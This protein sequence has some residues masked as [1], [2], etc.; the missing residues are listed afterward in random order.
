MDDR[1]SRGRLK[2]A[3]S[4]LS[5]WDNLVGP[6]YSASQ[7]TKVCGEISQEALEDR[8]EHREILGLQTADGVLVYPAFQFDEQNRIVQGLPEVFQCFPADCVND[9]ALAGW[10]VSPLQTL[11]G[12]SVVHWLR[13]GED[14]ASALVLARDAASRF[15]Q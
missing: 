9:W 15:C 4:S 11:D 2:E 5:S 12:K 10:L 6:F 13:D 1:D 7:A 14:L 8:T 3:K